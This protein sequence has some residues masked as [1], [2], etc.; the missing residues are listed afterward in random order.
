LGFV[1][2]S[3]ISSCFNPISKASLINCIHSV[4][5][6]SKIAFSLINFFTPKYYL[7]SRQSGHHSTEHLRSVT[8][9]P[10]FSTSLPFSVPFILYRTYNII[11]NGPIY[12]YCRY[13]SPAHHC[14]FLF[15]P[16]ELQKDL[17][18]KVIFRKFNLLLELFCHFIKLFVELFFFFY[19][20]K[21]DGD[22]LE[23]ASFL[24]GDLFQCGKTATFSRVIA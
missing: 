15:S 18:I 16:K 22:L 8:L 2:K 11:V 3:R 4:S 9:R 12:L 6:S 24:Y 17:L 7:Y 14:L 21:L 1:K 20:H 10:S 23:V 5:N 13:L 19:P